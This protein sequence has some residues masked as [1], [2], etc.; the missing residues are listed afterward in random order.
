MTIEEKV[1]CPFCGS[2]AET[3]R[4]KVLFEYG[5]L[6]KKLT[7][8]KRYFCSNCKQFFRNPGV[9]RTSLDQNDGATS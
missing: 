4:D 6:K 2:E 3:R 1:I 9:N 5:G 7:P 8:R